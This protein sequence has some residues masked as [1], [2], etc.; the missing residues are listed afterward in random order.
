MSD[1]KDLLERAAR[2]LPGGVLGSHRAGPGLE[3]VV[4][5]GRAGAQV[6]ALEQLVHERAHDPASRRTDRMPETDGLE[7]ARQIRDR[8]SE[9]G[10]VMLSAYDDPQFVTEALR[11]AR[12]YLADHA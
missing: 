6:E 3:F 1:Q 8:H 12:A 10:V 5:E 4:R 7:T 9:V 11:A 2:V